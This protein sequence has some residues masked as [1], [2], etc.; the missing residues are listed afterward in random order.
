MKY[1][2]TFEEF[3][4]EAKIEKMS[5]AWYFEEVKI[6]GFDPVSTIKADKNA[7]KAGSALVAYWEKGK[8][9]DKSGFT[10]NDESIL[11]L[12]NAKKGDKIE[13]TLIDS[14]T[15]KDYKVKIE[16]RDI[17]SISGKAANFAYVQV[18]RV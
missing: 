3:V 16:I 1:L 11:D 13:A 8:E 9:L 5:K 12:S 17:D 14:K 6:S 10:I 7:T 15:D 4:N 18:Y 2:K